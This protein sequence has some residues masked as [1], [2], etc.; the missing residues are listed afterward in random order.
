MK[1]IKAWAVY[2]ALNYDGQKI[3][4]DCLNRLKVYSTRDIA[5][6]HM[7]SP[8]R[9]RITCVEIRPLKKKVKKK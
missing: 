7:I 3:D 6:S 4:V 8:D 2:V 1:P 9:Q 5:R